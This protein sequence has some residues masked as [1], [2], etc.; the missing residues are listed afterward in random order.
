M[1]KHETSVPQE[2]FLIETPIEVSS[3]ET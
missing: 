3:I 1:Q 2:D